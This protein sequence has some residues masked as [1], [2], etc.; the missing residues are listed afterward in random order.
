MRVVTSELSKSIPMT[1]E[2]FQIISMAQGGPWSEGAASSSFTT[3]SSSHGEVN[4]EYLRS[5][6][7]MGIHREDARQVLQFDS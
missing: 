2:S 5:L 6:M 4:E 1:I 3:S 7:D